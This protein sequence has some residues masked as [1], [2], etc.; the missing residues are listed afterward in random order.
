[1]KITEKCLYVTFAKKC[2]NI[3]FNLRLVWACLWLCPHVNI[4]KIFNLPLLNQASSQ[5]ESQDRAAFLCFV[6]FLRLFF[7]WK[8]SHVSSLPIQSRPQMELLK[9]TLFIVFLT[10]ASARP[11]RQQ[12][13]H[14]PFSLDSLSTFSCLIWHLHHCFVLF[15]LDFDKSDTSF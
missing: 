6:M 14:Q 9:I 1:M 4:C 3:E 2:H 10:T 5:F 13:Q 11:V 12:L 8:P 15:F 7:N